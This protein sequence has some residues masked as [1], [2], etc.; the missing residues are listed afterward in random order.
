MDDN[1]SNPKASTPALTR[2]T[3]PEGRAPLKEISQLDTWRFKAESAVFEMG[4]TLKT[5]PS[6]AVLAESYP[7]TGAGVH[8]SPCTL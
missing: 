3:Y 4:E 5:I 6:P 8:N 2:G 7:G 1:T